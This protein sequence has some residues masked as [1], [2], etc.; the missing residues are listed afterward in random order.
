[1]N[2]KVN[3]NKPPTAAISRS[4]EVIDIDENDKSLLII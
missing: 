2:K 4:D 3:N 1:M